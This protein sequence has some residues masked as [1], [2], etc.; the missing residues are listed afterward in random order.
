MNEI[1]CPHC[2]RVFTVSESEY[3]EIANQ[4]RDD[5]M[6]KEMARREESLRRELSAENSKALIKS[7]GDMKLKV[8]EYESKLAEL[9]RQLE[10]KDRIAKQ[11]KNLVIAETENA[12]RN[13]IS[14]LEKENAKLKGEAEKAELVAKNEAEKA[15]REKEDTIRELTHKIED[16]QKQNEIVLAGIE[17]KHQA[18]LKAKDESIE[19]YRDLKTKM[20]TKLVGETLEQHCMIE[21]N[22]IRAYSFPNAQFGKDNDASSGSKGDFIYRENAE[23]GTELLSIMFEMKNENDTTA[24]KH[25]NEDFLKELDKDRREKKCEYA[26]LV[27]ML[28]PESDFYNAGIVDLSYE[29]PKMFAVRPQC[30]LSIIGLLRNAALNAVNA[31]ME[32]ARLRQENLDVS[33]FESKLADFQ[34]AFSKNYELASRKFSEAIEEIDKTIKDLEKVKAALTSSER[35]LRLAN[36]KAS[37]LSIKKL[38]RGNPTMSEAF[39]KASENK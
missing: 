8:Q 30:F 18:E 32:V 7:E 15:I 23:D 20:S 29:Y 17:Q 33:D 2:G 14:D 4:V 5:V 12:Y 28:E 34:A 39:K 24:S 36:D 27:T 3:N 26:V 35:N 9:H 11:E 31:K 21:F 6:Q 19:Y 22:R 16:N 38:T 1:K 10:A 37:D 25:K 13:K